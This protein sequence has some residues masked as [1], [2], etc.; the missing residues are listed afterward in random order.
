MQKETT[1]SRIKFGIVVDYFIFYN[2]FLIKFENSR[3]ARKK[4][5]NRG[6]LGF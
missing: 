4:I 1:R 5:S 2:L 6:K 3:F